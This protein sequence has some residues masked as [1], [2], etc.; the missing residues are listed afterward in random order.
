MHS[1]SC[2]TTRATRTQ[3]VAMEAS[4]A[5]QHAHARSE[6]PAVRIVSQPSVEP[7]HVHTYTSHTAPTHRPPPAAP[8]QRRAGLNPRAKKPLA[9][10]CRGRHY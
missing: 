9:G 2:S 7:T 1:R 8:R 3:A 6:A 10:A 5:R 4:T